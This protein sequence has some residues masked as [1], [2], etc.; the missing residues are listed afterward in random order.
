MKVRTSYELEE[1]LDKDLAWRK[2]EFT[3]LKFMVS[4]ARQHERAILT[5]ASIAILYSHW[6]GHLKSAAEAYICYLNKQ[7][8]Q[9]C[10][11]TDN[12]VQLSLS[13]KFSSG[14]SI[15]KYP[16]QKDIFDYLTGSRTD[17]F[18]LDAKRVIDTQSNLKSEVLFNMMNQLGL[19]TG[20]FELK[21]N[22]IDSIMLKHRNSIAH[23]DRVGEDDAE[24]AYNELIT[25]LL[26]MI[27]TFQTMI[28]N[29]VANRNYLKTKAA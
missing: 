11:M 19:D 2:K 14:F 13:D 10:E 26:D 28:R 24:T 1:F 3:T 17:K 16:S 12:F 7:S 22:F 27:V 25:E 18:K 23:G 8:H 21:E 5:R 9:Y 4:S 6:E 29:A 15:K 20:P